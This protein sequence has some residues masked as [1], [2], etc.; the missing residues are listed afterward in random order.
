MHT[1]LI[2]K[3]RQCKKMGAQLWVTFAI[4]TVETLISFKYGKDILSTDVPLNVVRFWAVFTAFLIIFP[5][6]RFWYL[7]RRFNR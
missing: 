1:Y 6:Y 2:L 4:I 3:F 7:P 5:I